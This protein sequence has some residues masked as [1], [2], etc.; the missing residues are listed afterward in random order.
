MMIEQ[1]DN[2]VALTPLVGKR[3]LIAGEKGYSENWRR[4]K[5]P[6]EVVE[7]AKLLLALREITS[8][9]GRN[10]GEL[11]WVGMEADNAVPLDPTPAMGKYPVPA[12]K[13][14]MMAGLAIQEAYKHRE[15]SRRYKDIALQELNLPPH[16]EYKFNLFFDICESVYVDCLSNDKVFGYYT[17]VAREWKIKKLYKEL[18]SPPTVLEVLLNWWMLAADRDKTKYLEGYQDRSV[19][20]LTERGALD[21]FYKP[22]IEVLN[23]I[24]E[25]LREKCKTIRGIDERGRA[26][27]ELYLS[28]WPEFLDLVKFWPADRGDK[29]LV[30]DKYEEDIAQEEEDMEA[31]KATIVSYQDQINRMIPNEARDYTEQV[32][33]NVANSG[34]VVPI[35][36]NDILMVARNK[37]DRK[38]YH[39]LKREV[40]LLAR[41]Q[42]H[43]NRGLTSGKIDRR[44]LF[45]AH[46]TQQ[47][48]QQKKH[49][50]QLERN[51]VLLVDATGS[52]AD[53]VKWDKTETVFQTLFHALHDYNRNAKLFAYNEVNG[54]CRISELYRNGVMY[55]IHPNGKTASG[56]AIIATAIKLK[57]LAGRSL[58][59]HITDGASNWGCGVKEAIEYCRK[60][61]I[62]LLTVGIECSSSI[63]QTLKADY[64]RHVQ[65]LK[66]TNELTKACAAM[67]RYEAWSNA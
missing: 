6:I 24:V 19:G 26:R 28:V 20:G 10:V 4:D 32:R 41:R 37:I 16:Y 25:P 50:Y 42:T 44:R 31:V 9:I 51:V 38:T 66:D 30:S 27:L 2:V 55:T 15:W 49:C 59:I 39:K 21:K 47:A 48:F 29:F 65:F 62:S 14:D 8:Y 56:E 33:N 46:T 35:E 57:H 40:M 61:R 63:R 34:A 54:S 53:P 52:M 45:R 3:F 1:Q 7:L 58:I 23:R 43:F 17:Q 64:G 67:L 22:P 5:S 12:A 36:G 18:I 11:V 13:T 60:R